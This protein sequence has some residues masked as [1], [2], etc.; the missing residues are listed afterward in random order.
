MQEKLE[1]QVALLGQKMDTVIEKM[2]DLKTEMVAKDFNYGN[3]QK[4]CSER[5][6]DI[7]KKQAVHSVKIGFFS[8]IIS[9]I[10]S[11]ATYLVGR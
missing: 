2:D 4:A 10:V 3:T 8:A 6:N 11:G 7:E 1:I 9:A 5:F